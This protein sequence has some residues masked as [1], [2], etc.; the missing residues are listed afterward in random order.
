MFHAIIGLL[1]YFT[2]GIS[3]FERVERREGTRRGDR[4]L[5]EYPDCQKNNQTDEKYLK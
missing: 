5:A 4:G 3:A 1:V 2:L